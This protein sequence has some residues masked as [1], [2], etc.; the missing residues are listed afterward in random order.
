[1]SVESLRLIS[2]GAYALGAIFF[3]ITVYIFFKLDIKGIIGEM[4]GITERKAINA[5][6]SQSSEEKKAFYD[7]AYVKGKAVGRNSGKTSG[8]TIE[9]PAVKIED[10]SI[11]KTVGNADQGGETRALRPEEMLKE[12]VINVDPVPEE[13]MIKESVIQESRE[14]EKLIVV[15]SIMLCGTDEVIA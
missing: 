10:Q 11:K 9:R 1:M 4:T 5:I 13:S 15:T 12:P 3:L 14:P 2:W 6:R 8:K 7:S